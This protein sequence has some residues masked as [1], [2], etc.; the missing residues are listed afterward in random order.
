MTDRVL[1]VDDEAPIRRTLELNLAARGY[2]VEQAVSGQ[3]ALSQAEHRHPDLVVLD[4]GLPDIDGIDVVRALRAWSKVPILVLSARGAETAKVAALDAGADD[5]VIKPFG[6]DELMARVRA[7]LR[8]NT[9]PADQAT[10]VTEHFSVDLATRVISGPAGEEIK[11]TPTQWRLVEVL[12]RNHGRLVTQRHLLQE[13]WGP[14][15]TDQT[16]YLRVFMTQVRQKLEPNPSRPR[17][18]I[19]EAGIGYR[20]QS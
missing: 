10:I 7:A 6:M 19:T 18:F 12:G 4:L 9:P 2:E 11:L 13:V 8:R 20:F 17:Y 3:M 16:N 1:V 15:Y 5:Y 14:S